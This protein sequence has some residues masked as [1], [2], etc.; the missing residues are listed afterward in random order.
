MPRRNIEL[1]ARDPDPARSLQASI[2]MGASDEGWLRQT[3]TY[4]RV[5]NGRLKLREEDTASHLISYERSDDPVARESRYRLVPVSDPAGLKD[6]L[7]DTLGVLVVVEKSRRL[8]LWH[9]VRIHLD[10]VRGLGSFIEIEAV[11][12]P[13]SDLSTE[14]RHASELQDALAITSDRIVAFSYSDEL[15]RIDP[16]HRPEVQ[17]G[18]MTVRTALSWSGGKDSALTLWTLRREGVEPEALITTVTDE[19]D[20]ISMHGVRRELLA[21]QADAIGAPL[22]EVRIPPACVNDV[23]E[24]RMAEAFAC[25]PLSDVEAVAFGDLFLEDVR[26]Y[27]EER[28]AANDR[29]GLFPLWGRD[30]SVLARG[31]I[32]AGF[33]ATIVC[34]DPRAL[35]ASF[36]GRAYD[37][38]LL[39][40]LPPSVDPCG[41]NGEF[42]TFVHGGPIFPEPIA[43]EAG[44]VDERDGF[45]FCDV[46]PA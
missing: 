2:Q 8:L 31:F 35:D 42:H 45:V 34:L 37:E 9:G 32:A 3:D 20:R 23:Y 4:F 40:D 11:A 12:D 13:A 25:P 43:C 14:H 18:D 5:R 27:R 30:T 41:E 44:E 17:V 24:T 36:A 33:Q 10:E 26:A 22:V 15:L 1:K 7:S 21:K 19:Y 6:A 39:A 29:R 28:L 46:M 38:Q 16:D